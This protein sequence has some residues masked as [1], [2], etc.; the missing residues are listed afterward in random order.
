MFEVSSA[1]TAT[2][3]DDSTAVLRFG[4]GQLSTAGK[5]TAL[6]AFGLADDAEEAI[7]MLVDMGEISPKDPIC[8]Q[9]TDHWDTDEYEDGY[10]DVPV[11]DRAWS[12]EPR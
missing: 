3:V 1:G 2:H 10:P 4:G 12:N 9:G 7:S 6:I 5:V 11:S 8:I